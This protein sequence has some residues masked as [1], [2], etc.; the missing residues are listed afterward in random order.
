MAIGLRRELQ[1][2]LTGIDV[3]FDLWH[4][5]CHASGANLA[6]ELTQ[7]MHFVVRVPTNALATVAMLL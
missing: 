5:L 7:L 3:G 4:T 6:I 2:H 1:H